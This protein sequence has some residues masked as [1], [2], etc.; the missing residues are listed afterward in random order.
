MS[1]TGIRTLQARSAAA[2]RWNRPDRDAAAQAY[3]EARIAEYVQ[4]TLA[5]APPLTRSQRDRLVLLLRGGDG[6]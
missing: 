2:K 5:A 1:T 3:A 4:K 6:A